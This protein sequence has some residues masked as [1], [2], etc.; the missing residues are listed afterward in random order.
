[1][2]KIT[3]LIKK[4]QN[5]V[6]DTANE[7]RNFNLTDEETPSKL[8]LILSQP[9]NIPVTVSQTIVNTFNISFT[10]LKLSEYLNFLNSLNRTEWLHFMKSACNSYIPVKVDALDNTNTN[11]NSSLDELPS[12]NRIK[13]SLKNSNISNQRKSKKV[14][15]N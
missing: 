9:S 3:D 13:S 12:S 4:F 1:M 2:L 7:A 14:K 6:E 5:W 10:L 11:K 8:E 15:K